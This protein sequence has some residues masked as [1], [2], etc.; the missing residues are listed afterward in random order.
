LGEL[1]EDV[2][3][4]SRQLHPSILDD[5]GLVEA[6][7]SECA[8]VAGRERLRIAFEAGI[9][10]GAL[11]DGVALCLYRVAQ[12]AIRNVVKHAG[13]TNI[14]VA[15]AVNGAELRLRVADDGVGFDPNARGGEPG[16]G[17]S[18]MAERVRMIGGR[19]TIDAAPGG[20]TVVEVRAPMSNEKS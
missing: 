1:A 19:L 10:P 8:Q 12:E 2:H 14:R 6:L 15:L 3:D 7:R 4:I 17:R 20:G 18:S 16:L 13:A 9:V 11:G 5:L